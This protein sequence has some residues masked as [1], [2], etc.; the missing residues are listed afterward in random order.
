MYEAMFWNFK[1]VAFTK[2]KREKE[3]KRKWHPYNG[4]LTWHRS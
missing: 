3:K 4:S 2:N 1:K